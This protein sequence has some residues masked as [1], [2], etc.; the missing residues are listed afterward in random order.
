MF[1]TR[2]TDQSDDASGVNPEEVLLQVTLAFTI[3]LGFLLSDQNTFNT[4]LGQ[5]LAQAEQV[6]GELQEASKDSLVEQADLAA[7]NAE[8]MRLLNAWLEIRS[9]HPLFR[10]VQTLAET[11][12]LW[13]LMSYQQL[14]SDVTF[15]A[16]RDEIDHLYGEAQQSDEPAATLAQEIAS[17]AGKSIVEAGYRV[18]QRAGELPSW[19]A[20]ANSIK[21]M[22]FL[23]RHGRV[24]AHIASWDNIRFL[25][26]EIQSDFSALRRRAARV[27][28]RAVMK[29]AEGKV[30]Q[31]PDPGVSSDAK[32]ALTDLL[33]EFD[34]VPKLLPEVRQQ[35]EFAR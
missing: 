4:S 1:Q 35:L 25:I 32:R 14:L 10:Q 24:Q 28:L 13:A 27:Q 6:Y 22:S 34:T 20:G 16:M 19:L 7:E 3:V 31:A 33:N 2:K 30:T 18:P 12:D 17:L 26:D 5:R 8:R 23:A 11:E 9:Q 29:I 21:A 15:V